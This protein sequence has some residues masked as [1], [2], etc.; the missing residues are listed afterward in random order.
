MN[1]DLPLDAPQETP[2]PPMPPPSA[3]A[4]PPSAPMP[5]PSASVYP[6]GAP[7]T[8]ARPAMPPPG[9]PPYVVARPPMPTA[10]PP[11]PPY[12]LPQ[13][14]GYAIASMVLGILNFSGLPLIG[15]ILALVFAGSAEK[16]IRAGNGWVQGEAFMRAGRI[17][18]WVGIVLSSLG[19]L[20]VIGYFVFLFTL[21]ASLSHNLTLP[22]PTATPFGQ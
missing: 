21:L 11:P 1:N 17:L 22:T 8:A 16:E 3:P 7:V 10:G 12:P 15:G 4:Y 13:T 5:P 20:A 9:I 2:P 6:P 14:S 18:G 19:I